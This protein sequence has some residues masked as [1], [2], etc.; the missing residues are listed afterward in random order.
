MARRVLLRPRNG[1]KSVRETTKWYEECSWGHEV[2]RWMFVGPQNGKMR[3][4]KSVD[5]KK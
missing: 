3:V 1:T 2:V 5:G 4:H